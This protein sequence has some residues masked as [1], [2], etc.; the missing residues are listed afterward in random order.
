MHVV[1]KECAADRRK[2]SRVGKSARG[3]AMSGKRGDIARRARS[4]A[5]AWAAR[6]LGE[7]E[8]EVQREGEADRR[9]E[10]M[11][12]EAIRK[13]IRKDGGVD[14]RKSPRKRSTVGLRGRGRAWGSRPPAALTTLT[15]LTRRTPFLRT[16]CPSSPMAPSAPC[17][18]SQCGSGCAHLRLFSRSP[19]PPQT[20]TMSD[21]HETEVSYQWEA[22]QLAANSRV[23]PRIPPLTWTARTS[24]GHRAH[25]RQR[26]GFGR[27]A[28][29]GDDDGATVFPVNA[30]VRSRCSRFS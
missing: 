27:S 12:R 7:A 16:F 8:D 9:N 20:N 21:D 18:S 5:W 29:I 26:G 15:T 25:A 3:R 1:A 13:T 19:P 17:S 14:G 30:W 24:G 4:P 6:H 11:G 28:R 22:E 10:G 23:D 2:G